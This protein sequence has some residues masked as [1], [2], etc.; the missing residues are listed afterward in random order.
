MEN[1]KFLFELS[2]KALDEELDRYK[3]LDEKA[4]RFLSILSIGIVAYTALI[5]AAST[6]LKEMS[7]LGF[8]GWVFVILT[9]LTFV[10]LFSA[11]FRIFNS[12][13]LSDSPTISIGK[14]VNDLAAE[15]E[16]ITMY[17]ALAKSCQEALSL[18]RPVLKAKTD[19]LESAYR[20]IFCATCLL[21]ACLLLYF[22]ITVF[23]NGAGT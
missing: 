2:K 19:Y 17:D 4:S 3:K 13:K 22:W 9:G 8:S 10:A 5:N 12:I 16:L 20:E 21:G 18:A 1:Y 7:S 15:E 6:K 23:P 11:W 14:T